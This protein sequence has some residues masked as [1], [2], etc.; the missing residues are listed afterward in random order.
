MKN[1]IYINEEATESIVRGIN[2]IADA[3]KL[4]IGAAGTNAILEEDLYP[5]YV[6]T[7]DG[8]SI[9]EK[10]HFEDPL[11]ELGRKILFD[12]VSRANKQSGDG[13]TTT[14][15]LTQAILA[16]GLK[17]GVSGMEIKRSLDA[18]LPLIEAG[19]D[20]QK[21]IISPTEVHAVATISCEDEEIG[22]LIGEVYQAIGPDGIVEL[23]NSK[24]FG[25]YFEIKEGVRFAAG[26][27][28]PYMLTKGASAEYDKPA[29]LVVR[30]RISSINDVIPA[31]EKVSASGKKELVI[32]CDD[33]ADG[34]VSTLIMNHLKGIFSVCII[35]APV[36]WKEFVFEDFAKATGATIVSDKT[37]L[38]LKAVTMTD[39]GS[40]QKII[41]TKDETTLLGIKDIAEHVSYL[42]DTGDDDSL[43]RVAWL[44]T[45]AAVIRLG[46]NS[47]SELSYKRLKVEDAVN[48]A[49][50]ALEDGVVVGGGVAL[51]NVSTGLP[52]TLGGG[53]LRE[54]LKAPIRQI[55]ENGGFE[56]Y[57]PSNMLGVGEDPNK[58][59]DAKTGKVVNMW[60][61]QIID[62]AKVIKNAVR[63][64][65]SVA[66]TA[67]TIRIA[68]PKNRTEEEIA[69]NFIGKQ[70]QW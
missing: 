19:I 44:T 54:A 11:E 21:R 33:I 7:N 45:K 1:N 42:K 41:V 65:I 53:I 31:I 5:N 67:L 2:K 66:G 64:A 6:I 43:R 20:A 61:A 16:E 26:V 15:I 13:S 23:D 49:R 69:K 46:A 47:E 24:T 34:V 52:D 57:T 51:L 28:S 40:C 36:L 25:T 29:I 9:L 68:I 55:V 3:V 60:D 63:N 27:V 70:Q 10:A 17:T 30:S 18:V 32:F 62:P 59:F 48:A 50:L 39:L 35:K 22:K 8:Y 37:G 56:P 38:V 58:G 14:T 12:S 4:T